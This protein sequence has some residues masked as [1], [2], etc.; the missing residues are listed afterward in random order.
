MI[1]GMLIGR[2]IRSTLYTKI[3]NVMED[4]EE[5][6]FSIREYIEDEL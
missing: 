5:I 1:Y 4:E 6:L 3:K 2:S